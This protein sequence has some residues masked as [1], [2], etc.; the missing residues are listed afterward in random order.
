MAL[1]SFELALESATKI[2][3]LLLSLHHSQLSRLPIVPEKEF[4]D[5][6]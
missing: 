5:V 3:L 2:G 6:S 1:G 4:G